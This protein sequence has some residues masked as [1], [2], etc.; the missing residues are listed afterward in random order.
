MQGG[1]EGEKEL[2]VNRKENHKSVADR[3]TFVDS[4]EHGSRD[5]PG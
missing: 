3:A 5:R 4:K 1:A 2:E